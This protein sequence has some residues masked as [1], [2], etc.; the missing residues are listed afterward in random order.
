[1][2][3]RDFAWQKRF[4]ALTPWSH[5]QQS[6]LMYFMQ[7]NWPLLTVSE[8]LVYK[9]L[10]VAITIH[11]FWS[12][13]LILLSQPSPRSSCPILWSDNE[14]SLWNLGFPVQSSWSEVSPAHLD[15]MCYWNVL[16]PEDSHVIT[17]IKKQSATD[18]DELIDPEVL[19]IQHLVLWHLRDLSS[20]S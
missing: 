7:L 1:M 16:S 19:S 12:L 6:L 3:I 17:H 8:V 13:L 2:W 11:S 15:S 18:K 9:M 10:G 20:T 14:I 4:C 5:V